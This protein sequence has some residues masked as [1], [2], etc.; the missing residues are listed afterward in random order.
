MYFTDWAFGNVLISNAAMH[1]PLVCMAYPEASI[2]F[3]VTEQTVKA[4]EWDVNV[5]LDGTVPQCPFDPS[6]HPA[7]EPSFEPFGPCDSLDHLGHSGVGVLH[8]PSDCYTSFY[9]FGGEHSFSPDDFLAHQWA[10]SSDCDCVLNHFQSSL[11][12]DGLCTKGFTVSGL[13]DL[14]LGSIFETESKFSEEVELCQPVVATIDSCSELC[15]NVFCNELPI[16]PQE[17]ISRP[18]SNSVKLFCRAHSIHACSQ[19]TDP[20]NT[21]K[22]VSLSRSIITHTPQEAF[23]KDIIPQ[24]SVLQQTT[25]QKTGLQHSVVQKSISRE[26]V[27]QQTLQGFIGVGFTVAEEGNSHSKESV[28]VKKCSIPLVRLKLGKSVLQRPCDLSRTR[29]QNEPHNHAQNKTR[30]YSTQLQHRDEQCRV[31]EVVCTCNALKEPPNSVST[32]VHGTSN[33]T[34]ADGQGE[35]LDKKHVAINNCSVPLFRLKLPLKTYDTVH[36]TC[37]LAQHQSQ[38]EVSHMQV[39]L[40]STRCNS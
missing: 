29:A 30:P 34:A 6:A 32:L 19:L 31:S 26:A 21:A 16:L 9:T 23:H 22:P 7:F 27:S 37:T 36:K 24:E 4:A 20:V 28:A 25:I 33:L 39:Q 11:K 3:N 10:C 5:E 17:P 1:S 38:H 12:T 2:R 40:G 18:L 14:L 15:Q 35:H 13:D 8:V